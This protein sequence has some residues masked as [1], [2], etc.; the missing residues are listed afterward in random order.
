MRNEYKYLRD[1]YFLKQLDQQRV[2]EYF[3]KINVLNWKEDIIQSIEGKVISGSISLDGKSSMRR[4]ANITLIADGIINDLT[5]VDNLISINKKISMEIGVVNTLNQYTDNKIIWFPLG[6]YVIISPS[7]SHQ[8]DTVTISLQLKDKM[9]LLDGSCGGALPASTVFDSYDTIDADGQWVIERPTIYQIIQE[10]VH[11]FGGEQLGKIIISDL[12]TRVKQVMKWTGDSPL[13]MMQKTVEG[14]LQKYMTTSVY[15][16]QA[17]LS[18][19]YVDSYNSPFEAGDDIG[20]IFTDFT[21]PG[22]LISNIGESIASILEK[23]KNTLGNYEFFYDIEGNFVFQEI[24][25]YLNNSQSSYVI[26][27]QSGDKIIPYK[28]ADYLDSLKTSGTISN[29]S[30][31]M[32][33]A[34]GRSV[35]QFTNANLI[36]SYSNA[37]QYQEIKN[38]FIIWGQ[39]GESKLPI[40]YHLAID[41]KPEVGHT[42]RCF[43][44]IDENDGLKKYCCPQT[45]DS[46]NEFPVVGAAGVYY[47]DLSTGYIYYWGVDE[48]GTNTY[49]RYT[50]A[51]A[52]SITTTDWRTELYLQG[53]I[54]E[55]DGTDS[56]PYYAEL[57]NEWVKLYD[58]EAGDF[59]PQ[60]KK[61]PATADFFLDFIDSSAQ[62]GQFSVQ[63]IGTRSFVYNDSSI[64]CVFEPT[65]PDL[66][67]ISNDINDQEM[68][69]IRDQCIRKGQDFYQVQDSIYTN[70]TA[71]GYLNS[72][73]QYIR[74]LIQQYTSYN[75]NI[76]ID[77]IPIYYLQPNTRI[78]VKDNESGIYGDY[79][80]N[81]IN[82]NLNNNS[83]MSI[84]ATK[85]LEK[86]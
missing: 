25:N 60:F 71:G 78:S 32:D 81:S 15:E 52:V 9:C 45:Y 4:T 10:L 84:S 38:D 28:K 8:K 54:A 82:I 43:S 16:Y 24:K 72:A 46:R 14:V 1:Y 12:D 62:A 6:V 69:K 37:P 65:V 7:I 31:Y 26:E 51:A 5:N 80:I 11:H 74:Q 83:T 3:V 55:R 85:A 49:I 39:K 2:K 64:N 73:Y 33:R 20:F 35:Y 19:G 59:R 61:E 22:E 42:Y 44:Y 56:N 13:Y 53:V 77:T 58:I 40:R 41:K 50:D 21:Y 34:R 63:N 18:E 66:V 86:I 76:S 57:K 48:E 47:Q 29:M 17:K 23:I 70:I 67:L 68:R 27:S 36:A 79:M 75:E 30:Y